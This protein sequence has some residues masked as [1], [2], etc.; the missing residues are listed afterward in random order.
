MY[1]DRLVLAALSIVFALSGCGGGADAV[2]SYQVESGVAQKGAL[3]QGSDITINELSSNT[4]L[5]NGK[6][7]SFQTLDNFGSF[8]TSKVPF[9]SPY[10]QTTAQGYYF[11]E[12]TGAPSSDIVFCVA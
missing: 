2:S 5:Q 3:L 1:F 11:N 10:L 4:Y 8:N 7:Y 9:S 12:L 6:S